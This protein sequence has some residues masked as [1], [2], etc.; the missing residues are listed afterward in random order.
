VNPIALPIIVYNRARHLIRE[1]KHIAALER[2][3]RT[4]RTEYDRAK[5]NE[6]PHFQRIHNAGLYVLVFEYDIT[7]LKNDALF[8]LRKWKKAFVARQLAVLLY[9][10]AHD[11]PELLGKEFRESLKTLPVS[12]AEWKC[13]NG[14]TKQ[15]SSFRSEHRHLLNGLRNFVGAHR[16]KDAAKQLEIIESID[17][18][19]MM[20]LAGQLYEALGELVPFLARITLL[21]ADWKVILKHTPP[22]TYGT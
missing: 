10:A 11:L 6:M 15:I 16:D 13:L 8:A 3:I 17:L 2:T 4:V 1:R 14:I 21:L 12:E 18:L 22:K 5:K 19:T 7:I 20:K 9:E